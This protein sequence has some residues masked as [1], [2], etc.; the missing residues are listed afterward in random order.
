M[1]LIV[2]FLRFDI[3]KKIKGLSTI[4]RHRIMAVD[5]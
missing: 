4:L 3:I 1:D 2:R 5:W